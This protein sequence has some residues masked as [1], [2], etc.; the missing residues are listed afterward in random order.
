MLKKIIVVL[1]MIFVL[2]GWGEDDLGGVA[3]VMGTL[4]AIGSQIDS[5]GV[6]VITFDDSSNVEKGIIIVTVHERGA[7]E[8]GPSLPLVDNQAT[9]SY[10]GLVSGESYR[11]YCFL[12]EYCWYC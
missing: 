10:S 4:P 12:E 11:F 8:N 1:L 5:E 7:L 2:A 6:L 3:K 9:I